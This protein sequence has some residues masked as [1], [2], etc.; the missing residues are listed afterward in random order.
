MTAATPRLANLF[1]NHSAP[2]IGRVSTVRLRNSPTEFD[3][4]LSIAHNLVQNVL[5][6]HCLV[7]ALN[8]CIRE[9]VIVLFCLL[10]KLTFGNDKWNLLR[11]ICLYDFIFGH[12]VVERLLLVNLVANSMA[13]CHILLHVDRL[14]ARR[15]CLVDCSALLLPC[16]VWNGDV[17]PDGNPARHLAANLLRSL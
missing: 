4:P 8:V 11:P 2:L 5:A 15:Q 13:F 17:P 1:W 12:C 10:T 14:L 16:N 6:P 7:G 9:G 3:W